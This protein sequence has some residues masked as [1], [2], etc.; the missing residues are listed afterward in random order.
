MEAIDQPI[1]LSLQLFVVGLL[2]LLDSLVELL[3]AST[4]PPKSFI[5]D[6]A[7]QRLG[8]YVINVVSFIKDNNT[9]SQE[10]PGNVLGDLWVEEVVM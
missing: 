5:S 4:G 7:A 10:G 9:I 2:H 6:I 3:C 8:A 1:V